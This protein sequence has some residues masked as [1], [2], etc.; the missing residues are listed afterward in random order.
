MGRPTDREVSA[1]AL[2]ASFLLF[3]TVLLDAAG[4]PLALPAH[5][6]AWARLIEQEPR[7]VLRAPRG[8]GKSTLVLAYLAWCVWRHNRTAAGW[9]TGPGVALFDAV[10][11][12][13]TGTQAL[14]LMARLRDLLLANPALFGPLLAGEAGETGRRRTR[15]S[16]REIRLRNGALVRVRA[17]GTAVRG[18]HPDLLAL[19]DVLSDDNSLTAAQREKTDRYFMGTLM[20]MGALRI[21]LIGTALHQDDLLAR[22]GR[23][24]GRGPRPGHTPLGF[25]HATYRALDEATGEP[26]WPERFPAAELLALRDADPL[27]FAREYQNAPRDD[28]SSL[29]PHELTEPAI[30]AWRD[31][32]LG[33]AAE[34]SPTEVVL[35][36][37]D[38]ARSGAAGADYT[39]M[40]VAAWDPRTGA[41]RVLDIRRVKGRTF[42]EQAELARDLVLR[43]G[44]L[45]AVVESNGFQQWLIDELAR[46][47]A[48]RGRV[49][50][51]HTGRDKRDLRDGI[52]RL[53][54]EL[55]AGSWA[56]PSGDAHSLRLAR[57]L[58]EELGS[59]VHV[60]GLLR[61]VGRHDD[62]AVAAW[63]VEVGIQSFWDEAA[64]QPEWE[65]GTAED[66]GIERYRIGGD[67]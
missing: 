41:R 56:V 8:H 20:P 46:D 3:I 23:R 47:P 37:V 28:A 25:R 65:Y 51:H 38:L 54:R 15:W 17:F 42:A 31:L 6:L 2:A 16:A 5:L 58:Q 26:L 27:A 53:A 35:M 34:L 39:A 13:A 10:L 59:F 29:I 12:S 52:P 9:L 7:M 36:G 64:R 43:Y 18:L 19:D 60:G 32:V 50:G 40:I 48:L 45:R 1:E 24:A 22:L 55:E 57:Q 49:L 11:F 21:L 44:V 30:E 67:W 14:E 61:S 63:L 4:R 33:G 62:L 66:L